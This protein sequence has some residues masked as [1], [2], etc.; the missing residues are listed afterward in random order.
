MCSPRRRTTILTLADARL[1]CGF[2]GLAR[3]GSFRTGQWILEAL[4]KAASE[5]HQAHRTVERFRLSRCTAAASTHRR[6]G[7]ELPEPGDW[8]GRRNVD[9]FRATH[10]SSK[11]PAEEP[12]PTYVQ[13]IGQWPAME[14]SDEA[15]A[16]R[17]FRRTKVGQS[18]RRA[19][20]RA[21]TA[22]CPQALPWRHG[23]ARIVISGARTSSPARVSTG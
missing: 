9:E 16:R 14:P 17:A 22:D 10:W 1:L 23:R 4:T 2:A 19:R 6:L 21:G 7:D 3:A 11:D 12:D 5:D 13:R 15:A 8:S 20:N 18:H